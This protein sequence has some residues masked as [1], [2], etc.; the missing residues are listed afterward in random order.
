MNRQ[1]INR[2]VR[3]PALAHPVTVGYASGQ[4][5]YKLQPSDQERDGARPLALVDRASRSSPMNVIRTWQPS[6][7]Y[8][9]LGEVR[10]GSKC[11]V[12]IFGRFGDV[13]CSLELES[14]TSQT[15]V[16]KVDAE[17]AKNVAKDGGTIVRVEAPDG[18]HSYHL[19]IQNL[20]PN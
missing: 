6:G 20:P 12:T 1:A 5:V 2:W 13:L 9:P 3:H 19:K 14:D 10:V 8:L 11:Q 18:V 7:I 4:T 15:A 17:I 16:W